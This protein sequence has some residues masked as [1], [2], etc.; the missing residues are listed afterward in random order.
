MKIGEPGN[1]TEIAYRE[2]CENPLFSLLQKGEDREMFIEIH[3]IVLFVKRVDA[4]I[5]ALGEQFG[6][7]SSIA[8]PAEFDAVSKMLP[9]RQY[10]RKTNK[11][12]C[13]GL[14][15]SSIVLSAAKKVY[16][17]KPVSVFKTWEEL[18]ESDRRFMIT[19]AEIAIKSFLEH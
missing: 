16:A 14:L 15:D 1:L 13:Q 4:L 8:L 17:S 19:D 11:V 7:S 2:W 5:Q 3:S 10:V 9:P 18:K 6:Y 12:N